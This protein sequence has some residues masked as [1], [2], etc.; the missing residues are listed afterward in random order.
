MEL[1]KSSQKAIIILH[2]IYGINQFIKDQC[3]NYDRK[4]F[5]VYC[6]DLLGRPAFSY[7]ESEKAYAYY[8]NTVG[9][10]RYVEIADESARLKKY[11]DK[12]F[13]LG[14]SVGATLAWR[15]SPLAECDGIVACCGSRIR[16]YLDLQ[17]S[18]PTHLLFAKT[19]TI[20]A[21]A[22]A[23]QL[24]GRPNVTI[25]LFD[26]AHGFQDPYS[27]DYDETSAKNAQSSISSFISQIL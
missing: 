22:T 6:P 10:D 23:R 17:P 25:E 26:A 11:Y 20:D 3:Q 19:D 5:D 4:G 21:A 8:M 12:V 15:C 14:F 2:E 18:H 16:D 9:F 1:R 13:L 24:E 7:D 27:K